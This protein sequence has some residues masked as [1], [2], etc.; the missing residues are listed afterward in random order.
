MQLQLPVQFPPFAQAQKTKKLF[1]GPFAQLRLGELFMCAAIGLPQL[2]NPHKLRLAIGKLRMRSIGRTACIGGALT[3]IL[4]AKEAGNHQH[5]WQ[6]AM[7]ACRH[8]HARKFH[9][10]WQ[11]G[12]LL[13]NRSE[14]ALR[15][16]GTQLGQ[17]LP[18]IGNRTRVG[19]FQERELFDIAK[20][21]RQ[22]A[23]N[24]A[25]QC[26]AADFRVGKFSTR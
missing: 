25:A 2:Q 17:L 3:R 18:T 4:D 14:L 1:V 5:V 20:P 9:I 24:H 21:Q 6:Y 8:Q 10:H 26:G 15:I 13:A 22:H 23:Q 16:D 11:F 19:R 12:H 7:R